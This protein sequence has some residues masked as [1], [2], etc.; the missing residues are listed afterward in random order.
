MGT[1]FG[2]IL[3]L[4]LTALAWPV[5]PLPWDGLREPAILGLALLCLAA[6]AAGAR[7]RR[8]APVSKALERV[9][10]HALEVTVNNASMMSSFTRVVTFSREQATILADLRDGVDGLTRSVDTV[11]QSAQ[12]TRDEVDSM[13]ELAVR[14]DGLLRE[15]SER[16]TSLAQ[17]ADGLNERFREVKQHTDDIEGI[18]VMIQDVAMQTNLLSLNAAI[19]AARAGDR[20]RGFAVVAGEVRQ[21]AGRTGE[22][23]VQIRQMISGITASTTAA[24]Q[25]LKTVLQ[26]I[27]GGVQRTRETGAALADIRERSNRTL[28]AASNMASAVQTQGDLGQRLIRNTEALSGA[29]R[30]SVE[31]VGKSNAQLRVVQ[32]LIGQLKRETSDL[33]PG[34]REVDVLNDCVE[35]MRACNI[36]IMNAD[37]FSDVAAVIERIAQIDKLMDG[38]WERC[39]RTRRP[40]AA[41][42]AFTSALQ[43]YRAVRNEVLALARNERFDEIRRKVPEQVRP[44]YDLVKETLSRLDAQD[45]TSNSAASWRRPFASQLAQAPVEAR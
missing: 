17:S 25:F 14:G 35:E 12:I 28:G 39:Q 13:H 38:T 31:W 41:G 26:D 5:W 34:R 44:A 8:G 37:A 3:V 24:D 23:T 20:G 4:V 42:Q 19:E 2:A 9:D 18:L 43:A 32:G 11:A 6:L 30:Q 27:Q 22:A 21:L 10:K 15:T 40:G 36:L 45:R 1:V 7:G 16:I 29:A 33:Q